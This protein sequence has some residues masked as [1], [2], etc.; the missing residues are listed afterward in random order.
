[1]EKWMKNA[2]EKYPLTE[3]QIQDKKNIENDELPSIV[4]DGKEYSYKN[5]REY[6]YIM[7]MIEDKDYIEWMKEKGVI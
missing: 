4:I 5:S 7:N 6:S 1:M 3:L 2:I